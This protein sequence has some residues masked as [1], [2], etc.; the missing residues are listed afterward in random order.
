MREFC[1]EVVIRGVAGGPDLCISKGGPFTCHRCNAQHYVV[2][3]G[4]PCEGCER[5]RAREGQ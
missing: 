5:K 2:I 4:A 1:E 3:E